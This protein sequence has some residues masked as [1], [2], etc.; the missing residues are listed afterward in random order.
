LKTDEQVEAKL[1]SHHLAKRRR[2]E[3]NVEASDK[4]WVRSG[5][6]RAEAEKVVAR[7][8]KLG[9][10]ATTDYMHSSGYTGRVVIEDGEA[11]V[12]ILE[13]VK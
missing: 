12:G 4:K 5:E 2:H 9:V 3:A 13:D 8:A 10:E 7:L 1:C 11:L 6:L